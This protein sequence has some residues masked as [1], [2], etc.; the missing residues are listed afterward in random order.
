MKSAV[1]LALVLAPLAQATTP[2]IALSFY[3]LV[4]HPAKYNGKRVSIRAYLVTSCE[5]CGEFF[6]DRA[7]ARHH[8]VEQAVAIGRL[9]KASLMDV[10]PSSRL[11]LAKPKVPNDGYVFV[12]GTFR[13]NDTSRPVPRSRDPQVEFVR[14]G[15]FGWMGIDDKTITD[16]TEYRPIGGNIPAGIN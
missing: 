15:G 4:E 6:A 13:Y 9:V 5:H 8:R 2:P 11:A 12:T 1:V 7:G 10:W 14:V 3:E 16:I